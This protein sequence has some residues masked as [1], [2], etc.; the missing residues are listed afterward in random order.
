MVTNSSANIPTGASG[1]VLQGGGVGSNSVFSTTTYPSTNA[2]STLLYASSANVM[3]A[4][5]TGNDGVLITSHTGVPSWLAGGT[6][7]QVLTAT[8]NSPPTWA[9]P[10]ASGIP[11]IGAST[12][13]GIVTWSGTGGA[14][15]LSTATTVSSTGIIN[16]PAGAVGGPTYSF[17]GNTTT[18]IYS[19]SSNV[20]NVATNGVSRMSIS[21]VAMT[22]A[23]TTNF[24]TATGSSNNLF[25]S[26]NHTRKATAI[27]YTTVAGDYLISV[28]DTSSARTITL[29]TPGGS[30]VRFMIIKD[31]SGAAAVNNI[32]IA[33]QGGTTID[34][35]ASGSIT[36]NYGVFRVYFNGTNWNTW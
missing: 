15:V 30:D 28:T 10:A 32:T 24:N 16:G 1:T 17:T 7:G 14:A 35:A 6:T 29:L 8:T 18:G 34:G 12:A 23:G 3:G 19:S 13:N 2:V 25:G 33:T 27:S 36:T 31:E 4:L 21:T 22:M 9:A 5:A 26:L 20:L 11:T